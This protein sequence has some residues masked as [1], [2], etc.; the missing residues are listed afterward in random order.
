MTASSRFR[1][2]LSISTQT[3]VS[4]RARDHELTGSAVAKLAARRRRLRGRI[5]QVFLVGGD[6]L[7][8][9]IPLTTL[10]VFTNLRDDGS[11]SILVLFGVVPLWSAT[12]HLY[13]LYPRFPRFVTTSTLNEL[14]KVFHAAL[15][16]TASTFAWL[17]VWGVSDLGTP[18]SEL[19]AAALLLLPLFRTIVRHLLTR[20]V[21]AERVLLVGTGS[22]TSTVSRALAAR[23]DI[24]VVDHVAVPAQWV[25]DKR[26]DDTLP[27]LDRLVVEDLVDRVLLSTRDL[28]DTSVG[29]FLH[30]SR[31]ANV[32]LTVLP[33]HFDVVGMG[34]A[35]DAVQGATVIS[36]Q[37]PALSMTARVM[38]RALDIVGAGLGLVALFPLMVLIA[39]AVRLDSSDPVFFRQA[40]IGRGGQRFELLK[41]RTMVPDA[42]AMVEQLMARSSDP[43]WL[44]IEDD[45]RVTRVG[46][47]LRST[48][49]DELPQLWNVL[50]GHMSLVGPRPLSVRDDARVGGWARG[51]LDI[52]PGLTGLWQ[53]LGRKSVPFEEMV[54]LDYVYVN[55]WSLWGDV[56]LLLQTLPAVLQGRGAR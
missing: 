3:P 20:V 50:V 55:N 12:L 35:I 52:T 22:T 43:H 5:R 51:R 41:F 14:P 26:G 16:A 47:V 56:K 11:P 19:F 17:S 23:S 30:W 54:K 24:R 31:R 48:S 15:V 40:R 1:P 42:D 13:G 49:L 25:H 21:G 4:P 10:L 45:P 44:Q 39:V 18:L 34:A 29:D 9:A 36:L 46:R 28:S 27:E 38:K 53:V 6:A 8:I 33:E 32:S 7:A 37:P 2:I